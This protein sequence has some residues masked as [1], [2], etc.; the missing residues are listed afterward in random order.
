MQRVLT[1]TFLIPSFEPL[2][3]NNWPL[4]PLNLLILLQLAK[5]STTPRDCPFLQMHPCGIW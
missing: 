2:T 4:Y 3:P 5:K 1:R